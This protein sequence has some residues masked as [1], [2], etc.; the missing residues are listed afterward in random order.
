MK[1]ISNMTVKFYIKTCN[2]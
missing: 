2:I 1:K